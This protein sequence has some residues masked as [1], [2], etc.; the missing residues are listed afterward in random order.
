MPWTKNFDGSR[1]SYLWQSF[2]PVHALKQH[3]AL[4]AEYSAANATGYGETG[5][6]ASWVAD[7]S[8]SAP[9]GVLA[10]PW[11]A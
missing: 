9:A 7:L 5:T 10:L 1:I 3:G 8:G 2:L 11:R 6:E 4:S